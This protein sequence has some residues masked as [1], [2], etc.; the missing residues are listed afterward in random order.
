MPDCDARP[1][2]GRFLPALLTIFV[3]TVSL[4]C[5][6]A[7]G[8]LSADSDVS[9]EGYFQLR[10]EAAEPIR[11]VESDSRD[12]RDARVVY[13][14]PDTATV[15]SG[16]P[17]GVYH[18]RIESIAGRTP[19]GEPV[20]VTVAHHSLARALAFFAVG[21]VVFLATLALIVLGNRTPAR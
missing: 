16:K 4:D 14:G 5:A 17:D 21:A 3:L 15:L 7:Q 10:W 12:F 20:S 19:I 18:Y 11:L 8:R 2:G 1:P 9:T 13:E 6:S